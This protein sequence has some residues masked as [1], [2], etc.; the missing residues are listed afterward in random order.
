MNGAVGADVL[1]DQGPDEQIRESVVELATF[2]DV[3]VRGFVKEELN[4]RDG[5]PKSESPERDGQGEPARGADFRDQD[6]EGRC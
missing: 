3:V 5:Q 4:V 6:E 2:C 1:P